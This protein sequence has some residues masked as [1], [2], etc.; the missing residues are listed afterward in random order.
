MCDETNDVCSDCLVD[1]D[2][3]DS[4][5]CT[6]DACVAGVCENTDNTDTCDD[7]VPCTDAVC[8]SG[9]CVLSSH[10]GQ[11]T[12]ELEIEAI[13]YAVTRDV[14][15]V[16][17]T[18][19]G[20]A[21]MRVIPV[22]TDGFATVV[23]DNVDAEADWISVAEGHTL[24]RL[25]PLTFVSCAAL[26]DLTG[27][28]R[29]RSGDF[30]TGVVPQDNLVD[31]TD[32]SILAANFN[33]PIDADQSSGADATGDGVRATADFT[34][35][36]VNFLTVG[37]PVHACGGAAGLASIGVVDGGVG[38][39]QAIPLERVS[40]DR[41]MAPNA[42]RADLNGDGVV[43][44]EDIR[45]FAFRHDLVLLPAFERKLRELEAVKRYRDR[46]R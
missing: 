21:D 29:L 44:A 8:Q 37:D 45:E 3:D 38:G 5:V 16:I 34:A 19:G 46:R 24:G 35:I 13:G 43:D 22:S 1:G 33:L 26:V 36:Q 31:I 41:L 9:S 15:F 11:V 6:D 10:M 7:G 4:N 42:W 18:C 23:V 32:F 28:D 27:T 40:V 39:L 2:C 12:V 20:S 14:T 30:H 25:A 17:T